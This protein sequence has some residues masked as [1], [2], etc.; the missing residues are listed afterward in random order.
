MFHIFHTAKTCITNV[1]HRLVSNGKMCFYTCEI[2]VLLH[3]RDT[4]TGIDEFAQ[5]NKG[6]RLRNCTQIG[7]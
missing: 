2:F 5:Q 4:V 1:K 6:M 7:S 3:Y